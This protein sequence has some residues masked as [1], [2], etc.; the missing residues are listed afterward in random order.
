MR[1]CLTC[2]STL[3]SK[4]AKQHP[5]QIYC[6]HSCYLRPK[7]NPPQ[8]RNCKVC[9]REFLAT[10]QQI[11]TPGWGL[12]CSLKC[13]SSIPDTPEVREKKVHRGADHPNWKGGIM[14][15]RKDR[16]LAVY[17][18]WRYDVFKRD[19]FTC[20]WCGIRNQKGLGKTVQLE[21][22]HVKS[23]T[24]YPTLRYEVSNGR[25]LC[26][27]CHSKRTAQQHRERMNYAA[28]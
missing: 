2:N 6:S 7:R 26:K 15:G 22:D 4:S 17:K 11:K 25:T 10:I 16:N 18:N 1:K 27:G 24:D 9:G 5:E 13:R 3:T 20:V 19:K 28:I 23:W 12:Y 14:K 8:K 21:A